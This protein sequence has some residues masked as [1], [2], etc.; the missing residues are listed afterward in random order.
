MVKAGPTS[1]KNCA[2]VT[3][4]NESEG[5]DLGMPPNAEPIVATPLKWKIVCKTVITISA[6]KGA[7]TRLR[8]RAPNVRIASESI[9]RPAVAGLRVG[10]ASISDHNFS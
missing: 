6:T 8:Y 1:E 4:G 3:E 10:I 9:A 5:S 7:G 2:N